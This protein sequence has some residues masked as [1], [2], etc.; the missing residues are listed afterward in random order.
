MFHFG[1][2]MAVLQPKHVARKLT[3]DFLSTWYSWIRTS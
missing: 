2:M 3:T 1:L